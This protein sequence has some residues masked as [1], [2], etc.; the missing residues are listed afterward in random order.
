MD[1]RWACTCDRSKSRIECLEE[2]VEELERKLRVTNGG[3]HE[4]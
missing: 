2:R 3:S 4:G 1:G